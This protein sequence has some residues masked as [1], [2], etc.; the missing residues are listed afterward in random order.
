MKLKKGDK[1]QVL[2]GKDRDKTGQIERVLAKE[3]KV[4][5][6]GVNLYKKHVKPRSQAQRGEIIDMTRPLLA[7]KVAL[8]CPKCDKITR[9]G[10][11]LSGS[12]KTRICRACQA[13][14]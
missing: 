3:G 8:I 9:V 7:S 2:S 12:G 1:V 4:L 14:I 5:V 11:K 13:E 6:S 10:Y